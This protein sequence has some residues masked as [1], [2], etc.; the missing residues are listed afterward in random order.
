[1]SFE[2]IM[3]QVLDGVIAGLVHPEGYVYYIAG[4]VTTLLLTWVLIPTAKVTGKYSWLGLKSGVVMLSSLRLPTIQ[5]RPKPVQLTPEEV[6][7]NALKQLRSAYPELQHHFLS[8]EAKLVLG[9]GKVMIERPL[10]PGVNVWK[11]SLEMIQ[12][13]S[14]RHRLA[15]M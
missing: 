15:M 4:L 13:A 6:V 8:D 11:E 10:N 2:Q 5:R 12:C 7:Q 1:M 9:S 3:Q 14:S